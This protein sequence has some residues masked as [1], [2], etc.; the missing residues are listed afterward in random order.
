MNTPFVD[1]ALMCIIGVMDE[2][3]HDLSVQ[4]LSA[5]VMVCAQSSTRNLLPESTV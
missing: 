4:P 3:Q 5:A 1:R 2:M